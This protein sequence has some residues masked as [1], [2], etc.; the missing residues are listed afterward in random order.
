MSVRKRILPSGEVRWLCD[1]RDGGGTRRF[2]QFKSRKEADAFRDKTG[3]DVRAGVHVADAASITVAQAGEL[4]LQRCQLEGLEAGTLRNYRAHL[5]LHIVKHLGTVKLSRLSKPDVGDFRDKLLKAC[6]RSTAIRVLVSL[7]SLLADAQ[8]RGL[9]AQNVATGTKVKAAGRHEKRVSIPTKAEIRDLVTKTGELWPVT[10]PWRPFV[11]TALFTG[12]RPSELRGIVWDCIDLEKRVIRV[13]QRA[14][15]RNQMGSPKSKAG[16]RD[17]PLSPMVVNVLRQWRLACPIK[18][19]LVFPSKHG[20]VIGLAEPHR[21]WN[22]LLEALGMPRKAYQFY[23]LRH[24]A[25]SLFIEQGWQAKKVQSIMGHSS[26]QMTFDLYGHLWETPE[27][28]AAAMAQIEARTP[29]LSR[30]ECVHRQHRSRNVPK[31]DMP[32][33]ATA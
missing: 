21:I 17:V 20:N 6:S 31:L 24:V 18:T 5:R 14:D 12:L 25:A 7:K 26:I 30:V 1:Y 27:D 23:D 28:D 33:T 16:T 29:A 19:D 4:W 22:Q 11:I 2:K 3:V 15:Y 8:S 13:R 9:V 32:L 10:S